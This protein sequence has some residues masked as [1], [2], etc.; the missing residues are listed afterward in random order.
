MRSILEEG[1]VLSVRG[2]ASCMESVVVLVA[3]AAEMVGGAN[4]GEKIDMGL[5]EEGGRELYRGGELLFGYFGKR[6]EKKRL[7]AREKEERMRKGE[8]FSEGTGERGRLVFFL[9]EVQFGAGHLSKRE[10]ERGESFHRRSRQRESKLGKRLLGCHSGE[11]ERIPGSFRGIFL[12][13][14]EGQ[15][16]VKKGET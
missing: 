6:G 2:V 9:M 14:E 13:L 11:I 16:I 15:Q 4:P 8:A 3:V 1:S 5:E 7:V 12:E 10:P